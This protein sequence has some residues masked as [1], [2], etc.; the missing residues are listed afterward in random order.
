MAAAGPLAGHGAP[1]HEVSVP[2]SGRHFACRLAT[3]RAT[4]LSP[5]QDAAGGK[6]EAEPRAYQSA[7]DAS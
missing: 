4:V 7:E 2:A 6:S 1:P 5:V 3:A